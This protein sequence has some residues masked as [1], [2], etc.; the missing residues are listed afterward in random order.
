MIASPNVGN[1]N[2]RQEKEK[3]L[4][5]KLRVTCM[6]KGIVF[7]FAS[8]LDGVSVRNYAIGGFKKGEW[9]E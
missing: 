9:Q 3:L 6:Q 4:N 2:I 1:S 8:Y 7:I 5:Y